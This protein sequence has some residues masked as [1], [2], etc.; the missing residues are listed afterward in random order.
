MRDEQAVDLAVPAGRDLPGEFQDGVSVPAVDAE[1]ADRDAIAQVLGSGAEV[2][3][4]E[5]G[6][7]CLQRIGNGGGIQVGDLGARPLLFC[8]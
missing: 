6:Q 7:F 2:G 1:R 5:I 3:L 8:A 4:R